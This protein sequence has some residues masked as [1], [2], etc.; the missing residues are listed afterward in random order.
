MFKNTTCIY[1][2]LPHIKGEIKKDKK[3]GAWPNFDLLTLGF[4]LYLD[5]SF[6]SVTQGNMGSYVPFPGS[7]TKVKFPCKIYCTMALWVICD[8]ND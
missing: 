3:K 1:K 7:R 2:N 4:S 8:E 5:F 6:W